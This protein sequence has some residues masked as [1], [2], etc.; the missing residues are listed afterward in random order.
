MH[1]V[2][3]HNNRSALANHAETQGVAIY[4]F[5][6]YDKVSYLLTGIQDRK[7][8]A[9]KNTIID[10]GD[11]LQKNF[12]CAVRHIRD[13]LENTRDSNTSSANNRNISV[14]G[15]HG[16]HGGGGLSSGRGSNGGGRGGGERGHTGG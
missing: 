15:G 2:T 13:Y 14:V 4:A 8:D 16:G 3:L 12:K 11:G 5:N 6:K 7:L 10:D 1:H 9:C